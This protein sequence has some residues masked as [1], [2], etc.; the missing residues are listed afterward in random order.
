M[1]VEHELEQGGQDPG[2]VR[3]EQ[4]PGGALLAHR[5]WCTIVC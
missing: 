2:Q 5:V 1:K 4:V 3:V